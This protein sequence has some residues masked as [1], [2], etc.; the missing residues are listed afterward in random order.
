MPFT[1]APTITPT[2]GTKSAPLTAI[3]TANAS[4][5]NTPY[6]YAWAFGDGYVSAL[7]APTHAYASGRTYG[8]TLTATDALGVAATWSTSYVVNPVL[9][10]AFEHTVLISPTG[11]NSLSVIDHTAGGT[12]PYTYLWDFGDGATSTDHNPAH[13]WLEAGCYVL[14]QTVTDADGHVS[15]VAVNALVTVPMTVA[16]TAAPVLGSEPLAVNFTALASVGESPYVYT[17]EFGDGS[18]AS[19]AAVTHTFLTPGTYQVKVG[20]VDG[21]LHDTVGSVLVHVL[22]KLMSDPDRIPEKGVV[23]FPVTFYANAVGGQKPYA[24]LWDFQDGTTSTEQNPVHNFKVAGYYN[25]TM[26]ITDD[27]GRVASSV[28]AVD[29]GYTPGVLAGIT[30]YLN[31]VTIYGQPFAV[32]GV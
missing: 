10:A 32:Y 12:A 15:T 30:I 13:T 20:V 29:A 2:T 26:T 7:A 21:L 24:Y 17:W 31:N 22:D 11:A 4:G 28:V 9:A 27:L 3:L 1:I 25:V 16:V 23:P 18:I 19:G 8:V 5:G 6:T 14:R